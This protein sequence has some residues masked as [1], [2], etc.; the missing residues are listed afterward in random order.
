MHLFPALKMIREN[1]PDA[2]ADFVVNPEFAGVLEFSPLPIRRKIIFERRKLSSVR[3]FPGEILHLIR[4][5]RQQK[6]D[7]TID[8]Q[9]LDNGGD[10]STER[11]VCGFRIFPREICRQSHRRFRR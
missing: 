5:I 10:K 4:E 3:T 6:Y 7:I 2:E 1:F 11:R 8:F 9:G